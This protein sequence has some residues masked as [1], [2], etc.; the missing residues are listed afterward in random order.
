MCTACKLF[1]QV[2]S[3]FTIGFDD[4]KN[5]HTR[6]VSHEISTPHQ[7]AISA[8][9]S[10]RGICNIQT[11]II[12]QNHQQYKYWQQVLE[13]VV[14]VILFLGERGLALRGKDE[15]IG[16]VH[17]G[18]LL[19]ILELLSEYDGFLAKHI[20]RY[21]NPGRGRTSHLSSTICNE[22]ID[23]IGDLML[24]NIIQET[25][26]SK[27]YGIIVDSTP[28][29][30]HV[31]QLTF[32]L[33]YVDPVDLE[34]VGRFL[35][36]IPIYSHQG[37]SLSEVIVN[38]LS[39]N[40]LDIM[41]CRFQSYDNASNMSGVYKG[42]QACIKEINSL[43]EFV[44]CSTH[45]LNLVGNKAADCCMAA[46]SFF[47]IV[48][49]LYNFL[50]SSTHRWDVFMQC[51]SSVCVV[52]SLSQTR[53]S[54]RHDAVRVLKTNYCSIVKA[55]GVLMND[56]EQPRKTR[57]DAT[58]IMYKLYALENIILS[59]VWCDILERIDKINQLLQ[60]AGLDLKVVSE[61]FVSLINYITVIRNAFDSY[62]AEAIETR[63]I[64]PATEEDLKLE[65]RQIVLSM[66][67]ITN[68]TN[69]G[70]GHYQ[71]QQ[72][73]VLSTREEFKTQTFLV[74]CDSLIQELLRRNK[75][76]EILVN[77]F[78]FFNPVSEVEMRK[79]SAKRLARKYKNDLEPELGNEIIHFH[80]HLHN[81]RKN[82]LSN[83]TSDIRNVL[84]STPE[85]FPNV[86]ITF[87]IYLSFPC[88]VCE[89]ERSFSKLARMKNE[90]R[91]TMGQNRLN[92]LSL[93]CIVHEL[94]RKLNLTDVIRK[95][96]ADKARSPHSVELYSLQIWHKMNY[97]QQ[98]ST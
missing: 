36:F 9:I 83:L 97:E 87:R 81:H 49:R 14:K 58:F 41:N 86:V 84:K 3:Q 98:N 51:N 47:G 89:G 48:Q 12:D 94:P 85:V 7:S 50:S 56:T 66:R 15:T 25:K 45:S 21:G 73:K 65:T 78:Y 92:S 93:M 95:F 82:K 34:P 53:W 60:T 43:A 32:I 31:D 6:I 63:T 68:V 52:K 29:L 19:G 27:Y 10:R 77:E 39:S 24:K 59:Y 75:V 13:R 76:Y 37:K 91:A 62:E 46:T 72:M 55:V 16:S 42:V 20:E 2:K 28:D 40:G 26:E 90:K 64:L 61:H 96:A 79:E 4:W 38:Y 8:W 54:A 23:I 30:S 67:E 80:E 71:I 22:F 44:P 33:R 11:S 69:K 74:I 17:N 57:A 18:N 35:Q 5:V 1:S 70:N 88:S